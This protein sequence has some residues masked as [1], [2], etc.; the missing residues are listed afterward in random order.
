MPKH[1]IEIAGSTGNAGLSA[2]GKPI[3]PAAENVVPVKGRVKVTLTKDNAPPIYLGIHFLEAHGTDV[4]IEM[5]AGCEV[6]GG[7]VLLNPKSLQEVA[8]DIA[9]CLLAGDAS[10]KKKGPKP[11]PEQLQ[12][13]NKAKDELKALADWT[14]ELKQKAWIPYRVYAVLGRGDAAPQVVIFRSGQFESSKAGGTKKNP[15]GNKKD[16]AAP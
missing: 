14:S 5:R 9:A 13:A 4:I 2:Q 15:K 6:W 10:R 1:E 8:D 7:A 3:Q 12:A 11:S 16:P